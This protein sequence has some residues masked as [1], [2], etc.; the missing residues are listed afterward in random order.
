MSCFFND[1]VSSPDCVSSKDRNIE[2]KKID[3]E[4]ARCKVLPGITLE[5][6]RKVSED[7]RITDVLVEI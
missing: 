4:V 2:L 6:L 1:A 7:L 5:Q 3:T